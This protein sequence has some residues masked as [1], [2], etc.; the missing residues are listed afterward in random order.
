M[1]TVAQLSPSR[2]SD[3]PAGQRRCRPRWTSA[4]AVRGVEPGHELVGLGFRHGDLSPASR[5]GPVNPSAHRRIR[6]PDS[7]SFL[8]IRSDSGDRDPRGI[9]RT[10]VE[11]VRQRH[12]QPHEL[13]LVGC[14]ECGAP[15]EIVD[16]FD[17]PSTDGPVAHIKIQCLHRHWFTVLGEEPDRWDRA[18]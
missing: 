9:Q 3:A 13:D 4:V 5:L 11:E 10:L 16:R 17:L 7:G 1:T 12:A 2:N 6:R 15:A 18:A 8:H 14:P